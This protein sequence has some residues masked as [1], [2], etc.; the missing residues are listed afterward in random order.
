[1]FGNKKEKQEQEKVVGSGASLP[2]QELI[3]HNMPSPARLSGSFP[4]SVKTVSDGY[5]LEPVSGKQNF[6]TIGL[7]I[8]GGGV[9]VIG[10]L[11]YLSYHFI[12]SPAATEETAVVKTP[13]AA[14]TVKTTGNNA[15][16]AA[17]ILATATPVAVTTPTP[18]TIATSTATSS[19]LAG[20]NIS[21]NQ[22]SLPPLLD[23]DSDGLLDNEE[24]LLGTSAASTDSDGDSYSDVSEIG[25]GYNPA[26]AGKL[27]ANSGLALYNNK[28][29]GYDILYPKDWA[30]Q[31][32]DGEATVI[33]MAPED[34]LI[35]V[36]VQD[37]PDQAGILG[38]YESAFSDTAAT[39]DQL[40]SA[41]GWDGVMGEDGLNFYL[42][43]SGHKNIYVISYIP[44]ISNHLVYPNIFKLIINSLIIK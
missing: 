13:T 11:I 38:W 29:L 8:I 43:D 37:N 1:M 18:A 32:L 5:N 34:S 3:I 10:V 36:S 4:N 26:G 24:V 2:D 23:S 17:N 6:K 7:V 20:E 39:Y 44:A 35:Q 42:T 33:F 21:P 15:E 41:D 30:K 22:E 9:I 25:K 19:L 16:L 12:I 31:S 14:E 27:S 40:L 28:T